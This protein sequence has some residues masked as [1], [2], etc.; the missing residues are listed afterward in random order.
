MAFAP[1]LAL[2]LVTQSAPPDATRALEDAGRYREAEPILRRAVGDA[3]RRPSDALADA[4]ERLADNLAKQA[5]PRE[6]E[7][8]YR[9][10]FEIR[11][12][13]HGAAHP[14]VARSL[15]QLAGLAADAGRLDEA[16]ALSARAVAILTAAGPDARLDLTRAQGNR[17]GVLA[18]MGRGEDAYALYREAAATLQ[19]LGPEAEAEFAVALNNLGSHLVRMAGA[20]S[21]QAGFRR[22]FTLRQAVLS[23]FLPMAGA[24]GV[25]PVDAMLRRRLLF[26]A[27]M[28]LRMALGIRVRLLGEMH[29][30]T[31][32]SLNGLAAAERALGRRDA[33]EGLYRRA[34]SIKLA[35]LPAG[36]RDRVIGAWSLASLI[37]EDGARA[38]EARALYRTAA[39]EALA[40]QGRHA[41]YDR[42]AS[43]E[44]RSFAPIF[45]GQ[46]RASWT[47]ATAR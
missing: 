9:R 1:A 16:E 34:L 14:A 6:A 32:N 41:D 19:R 27:A 39:T 17:A 2:L 30:D 10:A 42:A 46:V 45:T 8:F 13:R 37:V 38:G 44:L 22:S 26:D 23:P 36:D 21:V 18:A 5:R 3:G 24:G 40:A 47:L 28:A 7:P 11:L 4:A 35:M 43:A 20:T 12:A 29:P 31:A 33:A 25:E 15:S